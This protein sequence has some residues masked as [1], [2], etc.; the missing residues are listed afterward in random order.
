MTGLGWSW[1]LCRCV[2]SL[3]VRLLMASRGGVAPTAPTGSVPIF[4]SGIFGLIYFRNL[5]LAKMAALAG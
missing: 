4:G 1:R 3:A 5:N 2:Q